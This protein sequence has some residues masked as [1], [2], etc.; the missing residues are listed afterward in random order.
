MA[1]TDFVRDLSV[2][3]SFPNR[4]HFLLHQPD[5]ARL[6]CKVQCIASGRGSIRKPRQRDSNPCCYHWSWCEWLGNQIRPKKS[7]FRSSPYRLNRR[8]H[9]DGTKC[10]CYNDWPHHIRVLSR[11]D[12]DCHA[13]NNG[14]DSARAHCGNIRRTLLSVI[15]NC[16]SGCL[17]TRA[18]FAT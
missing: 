4:L 15:C 7:T 2:N 12:C 16:C 9:L 3:G 6:S 1:S 8:R 10:F 13:K 14:R 11:P 17:L 18:D 5:H